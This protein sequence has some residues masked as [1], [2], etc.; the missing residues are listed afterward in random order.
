VN[1]Y[2]EVVRAG[3]QNSSNNTSAAKAA[4]IIA[5]NAQTLYVGNPET[6]YMA[7]FIPF[8]S[9]E[10]SFVNETVYL[11]SEV[12][13]TGG[14]IQA[15][16]YSSMYTEGADTLPVQ[17]WM[18]NTT[19]TDLN[20]GWLPSGDYQL[21]FQGDVI[22]PA[23]YHEITIP[24]DT[25]FNYMGG[26]VAVRIGKS[27]GAVG[28]FGCWWRVT[29]DFYYP[30][31]VRASTGAV[32]PANPSGGSLW[33]YVP[34]ITFIMTNANL[35]ETLAAPV[36]NV[37]VSEAGVGLN[38]ELIPYAHSYNIYTSEEPY[39]FGDEPLG[40][41]YTNDVSISSTTAKLFFKVT[42][43][44]YRD[45]GRAQ[46]GVLYPEPKHFNSIDGNLIGG[47]RKITH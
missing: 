36:V 6:P 3:D 24:L 23:G 10:A 13:A 5:A 47:S 9:N 40:T 27:S 31:R 7:N 46:A 14:T 43:K 2:A 22:C 4:Y 21:V 41:V 42:A 8:D 25:H 19:A 16:S 28:P 39:N 38:W 33:D 15:V 11:A 1:V 30:D 34:N 29:G 45:S 32:D 26:N 20:D 12:Q 17:I 44:T 37:T 18:K 35:V